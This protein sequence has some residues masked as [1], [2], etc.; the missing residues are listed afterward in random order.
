M[1]IILEE[2]S[3][4]DKNTEDRTI[5]SDHICINN[6]SCTVYNNVQWY[7]VYCRGFFQK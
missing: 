5:N 2:L 4:T 1:L 6:T 7:I 3:L